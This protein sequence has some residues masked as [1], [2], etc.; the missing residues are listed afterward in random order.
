MISSRTACHHGAKTGIALLPKN[1][2]PVSAGFLSI[3]MDFPLPDR[4]NG[5]RSRLD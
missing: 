3:L 2:N 4:R 5:R 1:K